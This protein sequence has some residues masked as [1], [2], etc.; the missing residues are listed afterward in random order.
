MDAPMTAAGMWS[1]EFAPHGRDAQSMAFFR[2]L[3]IE[4]LYSGVT[5]RTASTAAMD[6]LSALGSGGWSLSKSG[7]YSGRVP[8]GISVNAM[9]SGARRIRARDSTRLIDEED[10]LPTK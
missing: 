1:N 9:S 8:M 10:R 6:T 3:G 4:R 5:K 7:L 2:A